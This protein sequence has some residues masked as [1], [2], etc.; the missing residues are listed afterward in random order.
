MPTPASSKVARRRSSDSMR[1]R[2]ARFLSLM[3]RASTCTAVR[4]ALTNGT[5]ATST[6]TV[7]PSSLTN[8]SST[9]A[10]PRPGFGDPRDALPDDLPGLRAHPVDD[11]RPEQR[12]GESGPEQRLRRRVQV[13]EEPLLVDHHRVRQ[14]LE[15]AAI[16]QLAL[17][18][19]RLDAHPFRHVLD[20]RHD[21][22]ELPVRVEERRGVDR[23]QDTP[24]VRPLDGV[25]DA[26]HRLA[27]DA[28]TLANGSCLGRKGSALVVRDPPLGGVV[29]PAADIGA[30]EAEHG[31]GLRVRERDAPLAVHLDDPRG[32]G[33]EETRD[34]VA[35]LPQLLRVLGA[36]GHVAGQEHEPLLAA[37]SLAETDSSNQCLPLGRSRAIDAAGVMAA[38][39]GLLEGRGDHAAGARQA[40]RPARLAPGTPPAAGT[41]APGVARGNPGS[42]LRDRRRTADRGAPRVSP[43]DARAPSRPSPRS[44]GARR[45]PRRRVAGC[46]AG[47]GGAAGSRARPPR[48]RRAR[49][50]AGWPPRRSGGPRPGGSGADTR[51]RRQAQAPH[52]SERRR[53]EGAQEAVA[54]RRAPAQ[55]ARPGAW[56]TEAH[57]AD[58][59]ASAAGKSADLT[60]PWR[61][62]AAPAPG[63]GPVAPAAGRSGRP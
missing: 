27:W 36:L 34:E 26:S 59:S 41:A 6:P 30:A 46:C 13:G 3:S 16:A 54:E 45:A 25:L 33:V 4:P 40:G 7:E 31:L 48:R 29:A 53:H 10:T 21:A 11:G 2:S 52:R 18:E 28:A 62:G 61:T 38:G 51:R 56:C 37:A 24:A 14:D 12:V 49:S 55:L 44:P 39:R 35:L 47:A 15:Q 8:C 9:K 42:G 23:K 22:V 63:P 5:A 58:S 19:R 50:R 43:P 60:P 1:A 17:A 32:T 20:G 57:A